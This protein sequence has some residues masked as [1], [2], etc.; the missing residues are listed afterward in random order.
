MTETERMRTGGKCLSRESYALFQKGDIEAGAGN[1]VRA[2]T[3]SSR[4]GVRQ[5]E[6]SR[7]EGF[8]RK[9]SK[10]RRGEKSNNC[11]TETKYERFIGQEWGEERAQ[12]SERGLQQKGRESVSEGDTEYRAHRRSAGGRPATR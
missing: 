11:E 7:D 12:I 10:S 6:T 2:E 1:E 3:D 4:H 8:S 5:E 9:G